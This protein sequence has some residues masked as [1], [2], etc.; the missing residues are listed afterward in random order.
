MPHS[1][2]RAQASIVYM[3]DE[4]EAN[5]KDQL[6][7]RLFFADPRIPYCAQHESGRL[8]RLLI[9]QMRPGSMVMFPGMTVHCVNPYFGNKPRVTISW[10]INAQALPGDPRRVFE[11][12]LGGG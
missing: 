4:G 12:R 3:V 5:P 2:I 1:H 6:Q 11:G 10:N 8:T 7:G 9:P